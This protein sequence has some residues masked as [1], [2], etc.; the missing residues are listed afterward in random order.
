MTF[1]TKSDH[2]TPAY[3]HDFALLFPEFPDMASPDES[4]VFVAYVTDPDAKDKQNNTVKVYTYSI[5]AF[6]SDPQMLVQS[7]Q[8]MTC[9]EAIK[10]RLCCLHICCLTVTSMCMS[11]RKYKI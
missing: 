6:I 3:N 8:S 2:E 11:Q 5:F 1:P 7:C 4:R 10:I 9:L